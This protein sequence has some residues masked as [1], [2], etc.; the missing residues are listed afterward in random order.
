MVFRGLAA[1]MAVLLAFA[2]AVNL[3]DPDAVRWVAI[4]GAACI[5]SILVALVGGVPPWVPGIVGAIGL[6]WAVVWSRRVERFDLYAHMFDEWK[7]TSIAIEEARETCGLL[8]VAL[9]MLAILL[10]SFVVAE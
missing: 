3:N 7:M 9:W 1:L 5:V 4:Y 6:V 10:R 8:I 2:A